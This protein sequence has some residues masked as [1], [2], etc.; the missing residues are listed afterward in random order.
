MYLSLTPALHTHITQH[1]AVEVQYTGV[2]A[3]ATVWCEWAEMELRN[4]QYELALKVVQE[5]VSVPA[6]MRRR[7]WK[8]PNEV[9]T[10]QQR[11]HRSTRLW[12]LYCD[13]EENL[14]TLDT[15]RAAYNRAIELRVAS[16]VMIINYAHILIEAKYYED[17]FKVYERGVALFEF[18][19]VKE[20]W[21]EYLTA[22]VE[23]YG[24]RK[25]ERARDLFEQAVEGAPA[26]VCH[27]FFRLYANL[28][29]QY[30]LVRH[31]LR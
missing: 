31:M 18:P 9:R 17:A 12:T 25:L 28:E 14:G 30:G 22:F 19:H 6:S 27:L 23:R 1:Q 11:V 20:I 10:V 2:N 16:P 24:G 13:L 26:D 7:G 21:I 3:L 4:Q 8:D 15:T 5:A 29:E